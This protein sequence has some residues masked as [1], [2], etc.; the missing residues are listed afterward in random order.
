MDNEWS[1][2]DMLAEYVSEKGLG[3]ENRR[4]LSYFPKEAILLKPWEYNP[5][6]KRILTKFEVSWRCDGPFLFE[7]LVRGW[8]KYLTNK[9]LGVKCSPDITIEHDSFL[10]VIKVAI[11]VS[12]ECF[13]SLAI[14]E[15]VPQDAETNEENDDT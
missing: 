4:S 5:S 6:Q 10:E 12:V 8:L 14:L 15:E 9:A 3:D 1:E 2:S 7:R 13:R 11:S